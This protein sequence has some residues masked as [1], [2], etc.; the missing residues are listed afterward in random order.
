[1]RQGY[2]IPVYNHGK[3]TGP[4]VEKL[5]KARDLPVIL[6]DDGSDGETKAYLA[7]TAGTFPSVVLVALDKNR[8]KGAALCAG[9]DRARELGLTHLLQIDADGQHDPGQA[10]FFMEESAK[11]PEAAICGFPVF[12]DSAP[13]SRVKGRIIANVWTRITTL[14]PNIPDAMCGFRVYPVEPLW[15]LSRR[16]RLDPRMGI[17]IEILVRLVWLG[18]PLFFHPVPVVYPPDGISHFRLVQDNIRISLVFF[19]LF[20]GMIF[21][22]PVL[23]YRRFRARGGNP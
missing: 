2:L 18:V 20:W 22:L 5:L 11:H 12:D 6:V 9:I 17:D 15:R 3:T 16:H 19:R 8:G 23:I 10:A 14:S 13:V 21:R 7:D 1:M 4:L